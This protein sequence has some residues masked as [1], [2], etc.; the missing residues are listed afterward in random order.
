MG[1]WVRVEICPQ[2]VE[3]WLQFCSRVNSG[4]EKFLSAGCR[5]ERVAIFTSG[6]LIAVAMQR[7]LQLS[8]ESTLQASWMSRNSSWGEF[9]YAGDRFTLSSF[10]SH[11]HI[12][13]PA[14]P[15]YR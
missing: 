14:M 2:G 10:N 1:K 4:L 6:S 8:S 11:G 13:D 15:T 12:G 9:L 7:A 5:R 3:T